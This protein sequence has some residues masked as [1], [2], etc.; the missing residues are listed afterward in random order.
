[1]D[2]KGFDMTNRYKTKKIFVGDVGVGGDSPVSVQSMTFSK[3]ENPF[4]STST[5][6]LHSLHEHN[7][8]SYNQYPRY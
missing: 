4:L 7:P 8:H 2:I 5:T 6:T 1:V 3:T